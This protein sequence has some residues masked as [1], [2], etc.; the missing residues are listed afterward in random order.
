MQL[1]GLVCFACVVVFLLLLFFAVIKVNYTV[2]CD[3]CCTDDA[4]TAQLHV[5]TNIGSGVQA[6]IVHMYQT[7]SSAYDNGLDTHEVNNLDDILQVA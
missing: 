2:D 5:T 7:G 4:W 1:T 3:V 6:F